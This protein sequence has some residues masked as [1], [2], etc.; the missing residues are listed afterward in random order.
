M[1]GVKDCGHK[2][3]E[4]EGI[5]CDSPFGH[6]GFHSYIKHIEDNRFRSYEWDD[7]GNKVHYPEE[8]CIRF[9]VN[10]DLG[11]DERQKAMDM[12]VA[13]AKLNLP[14]DVVFE[15]RSKLIPP[16][17]GYVSYDFRRKEIHRD[18][19]AKK[20]GIAWYYIPYSETWKHKFSIKQEPLFCNDVDKGHRDK[21]GGYIL[22]ARMLNKVG[23]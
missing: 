20:W 2:F 19:L 13:T 3:K 18:E 1:M 16:E 17:S 12:V 4:V 7:S 22:L 6:E 10:Y 15:I 11:H 9:P 14:V 21:L 5:T 8:Q 23:S